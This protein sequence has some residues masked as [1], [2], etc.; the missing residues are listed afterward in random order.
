MN[1][2][3]FQG[4]EGISKTGENQLVR[5]G[6][7]APPE[8]FAGTWEFG[9]HTLR[10]LLRHGTD[11]GLIQTVMSLQ[12]ERFSATIQP[13]D[14]KGPPGFHKAVAASGL[15]NATNAP[16]LDPDSNDPQELTIVLTIDRI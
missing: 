2:G 3:T 14:A 15:L 6:G 16:D 11:S 1:L 5:P 8:A 12:G 10:R 13:L 9:E 7:M 4:S